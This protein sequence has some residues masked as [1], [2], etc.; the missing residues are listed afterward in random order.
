MKQLYF[1]LPSFPFL[2]FSQD[3]LSLEKIVFRVLSSHLF[4]WTLFSSFSLTKL[5][6]RRVS[7]TIW[8]ATLPTQLFFSSPSSFRNTWMFSTFILT[9]VSSICPCHS[10][11]PFFFSSIV[12]VFFQFSCSSD[13]LEMFCVLRCCSKRLTKKNIRGWQQEKRERDERSCI[14]CFQKF[15]I[16]KNVTVS[17]ISV[18]GELEYGMCYQKRVNWEFAKCL[19]G[20]AGKQVW[21]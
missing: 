1:F 3:L 20:L 9:K 16:S 5:N 10:T 4:C 6:F 17:E 8:H 21:K 14:S 13:V 7:R 15:Q 19:A 2:N 12:V 18:I 11:F